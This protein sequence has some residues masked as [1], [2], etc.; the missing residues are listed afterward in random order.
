M[1][2]SCS[3]MDPPYAAVQAY[4]RTITIIPLIFFGLVANGFNIRIFA[5]I[6]MRSSMVN[7]FLLAMAISDVFV[8]VSTFFML[9]F[10]IFAETSQSCVL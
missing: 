6:Q 2:V 5:N 3:F 8:L 1:N 7:W 10:P 9:A 4:L